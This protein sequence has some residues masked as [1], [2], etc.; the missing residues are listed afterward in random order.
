MSLPYQIPIVSPVEN[1]LVQEFQEG[2]SCVQVLITDAY[3][4]R[5]GRNYFRIFL[6][7]FEVVSPYYYYP[8]HT[9]P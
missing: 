8:C 4:A 5:L 1:A 9:A 7:H 6:V 3:P 2:S